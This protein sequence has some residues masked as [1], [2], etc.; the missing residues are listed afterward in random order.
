MSYDGY[1][2][3]LCRNGHLHERNCY[4]RLPDDWSCPICNEPQAWGESVD[5]T[6]DAGTK[7]ALQVHKPAEISTCEHCGLSKELAPVCYCI[8][9]SSGH[10][11]GKPLV[12]TVQCG[13]TLIETDEEFSTRDELNTAYDALWE[14]KDAEHQAMLDEI[15]ENVLASVLDEP[16]EI[17]LRE[18]TDEEAKLEIRAF[19]DRHLGADQADIHLELKINLEQVKRLC[20]ELMEEGV[21]ERD[22][23]EDEETT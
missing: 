7:T 17:I 3:T 18:I 11:K 12:P 23:E 19:I 1:E 4:D 2:R 14:K 22:D 9:S 10:C 8:P 6:N 16:E 20:A 15:K 5:Q 21:I 13:F